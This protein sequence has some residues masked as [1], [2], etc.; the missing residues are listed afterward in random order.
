M[1]TI[2]ISPGLHPLC[3]SHSAFEATRFLEHLSRFRTS[4]SS[5]LA[6]QTVHTGDHSNGLLLDVHLVRRTAHVEH[7]NFNQNN[8]NKIICY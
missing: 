1:D 7:D 5:F 8:K 3:L 2:A 4:F 6:R